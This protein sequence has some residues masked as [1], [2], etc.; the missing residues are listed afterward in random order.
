MKILEFCMYS[1][2]SDNHTT[3]DVKPISSPDLSPACGPVAHVTTTNK[4]SSQPADGDVAVK[5]EVDL[6]NEGD[7]EE[8][9]GLGGKMFLNGCFT[10]YP[11]VLQIL[12]FSVSDHAESE[13]R[14][15][16]GMNRRY[17]VSF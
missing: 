11:F 9:Q 15:L 14:Q 6:G 7:D 2:Q 5:M 4:A 10:L 13:Q 8:E 12:I 3:I 17:F 16:R 1:D